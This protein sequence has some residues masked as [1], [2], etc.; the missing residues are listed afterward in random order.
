MQKYLHK[1]LSRQIH[2]R[3]F[4]LAKI[5]NYFIS[6][7]YYY[8]LLYKCIM[9]RAKIA[10]K[11]IFMQKLAVKIHFIR[12]FYENRKSKNEK[13]NMKIVWCMFPFGR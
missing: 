1:Y 13:R 9:N 10:F 11:F 5:V 12:K 6:A 8:I 3:R 2:C 7:K 4:S